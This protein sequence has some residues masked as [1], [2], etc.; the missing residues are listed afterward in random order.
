MKNI[1][2]NVFF[3]ILMI[4][5]LVGAVG[6][7]TIDFLRFRATTLPATGKAGE[8]RLDSSTQLVKKWNATSSGWDSLGGLSGVV[9]IAN[10]GTNNGSLGVTAGGVIYTEG[11]MLA[12]TGPGT[13][14]QILTSNGSASPV[15]A[16]RPGLNQQREYITGGHF[17]NSSASFAAYAD[18]AGSTPVDGTGGSP[19]S[20][21]AITS[22]AGEVLN[23][24]VSLEFVKGAANR[25]GEGFSRDFTID[26]QE[27]TNLRCQNISFNYKATANYPNGAINVFV[28]DKDAAVLLSVL[29]HANLAGALLPSTTGTTFN[30]RFCP[31]TSTSND[32][33]LI[34]HVVGTETTA[35]DFHVDNVSV[36]PNSQVPGAI[37]T[38]WQSFT[39]TGSWS[40]NTT[41]TGKWRRIGDSAEFD[42]VL[43]LAG[44]PTASDLSINIPTSIGTIDTAKT[45]SSTANRESFGTVNVD[46]SGT[47]RYVGGVIY[48]STSAVGLTHSESGN[49]GVINATNPVTFGSS[50]SVSVRF[51]V[52]ISNWAASAAL[53][54]TETM[55]VSAKARYTGT[56]QTIGT[57]SADIL[58][59]ST[60]TFDTLNSVT[61]GASWKFTSPKSG[62]YRASATAQYVSRVY[63]VSNAVLIQLFKNG[64]FYSQGSVYDVATTTSSIVATNHTDTIYLAKGDYIDFRA[65]NEGSG[66]TNT[67]GFHIEVEELPDFSIFSTY[68]TTEQI[69]STVQSGSATSLTTTT[70]K[71]VTSISLT[72][73]EWDVTGTVGFLIGGN[74]IQV[75]AAISTTNNTLPSEPWTG[76]YSQLGFVSGAVSNQNVP[77][78]PVTLVLTSTTTVYLIA[79]CTF[80]SSTATAYGSIVARRIK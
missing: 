36:S 78:A 9:G 76:G 24:G 3:W 79:R 64:S 38:E 6:G 41:Y 18:A 35:W 54:T 47:R 55:L 23:G 59:A 28:Y 21:V 69:T 37:V 58:N 10:G 70:A 7:N 48:A 65:Y 34:W 63:A 26:Y 75:V 17:E 2:T 71:T 74:A 72:P 39:P 52:P 8:V 25:Q 31:T 77:I 19:N 51:K 1:K 62:Y 12:N 40:T 27:H 61:T 33:R 66:S 32:Y 67:D 5:V 80:S 13:F 50:D 14:D 73:G 42:I 15:W 49:A 56:T 29:D 44:A 60:K 53:S 30:G 22:T 68:G 57:G 43:T 11:S 16:P 45:S 4:L 20:S 46:D